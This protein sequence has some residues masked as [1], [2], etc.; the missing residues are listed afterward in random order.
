MI[1]TSDAH[2]ASKLLY[3]FEDAIEYARSCGLRSL[4]VYQ[5]GGFQE[6]SIV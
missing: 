4:Y 5:N 2:M 6:F 3:G 1:I